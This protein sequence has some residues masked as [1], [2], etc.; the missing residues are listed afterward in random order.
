MDAWTP[1]E[2]ARNAPLVFV[3]SLAT[4]VPLELLVFDSTATVSE[5]VVRGLPTATGL[6]FGFAFVHVARWHYE[7]KAA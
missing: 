5:A 3:L 4:V 7:R 6:A 1:R 2:A